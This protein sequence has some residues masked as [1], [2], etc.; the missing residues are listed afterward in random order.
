MIDPPSCNS[1]YKGYIVGFV[2]GSSYLPIIPLLQGGGPP[3]VTLIP[4]PNSLAKMMMTAARLP[5][6]L[7]MTKT[8]KVQSHRGMK[9]CVHCRHHHTS[10]LH[11]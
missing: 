3:M 9:D 1:D 6:L 4:K 5:S 10:T 2:L 7:L 11:P 8:G